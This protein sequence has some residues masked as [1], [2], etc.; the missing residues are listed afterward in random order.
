MIRTIPMLAAI[1]I[2]GVCPVYA[3]YSVVN[4]GAWPNEWPKELEPLRKQSRTFD[5]PNP[6]GT[7]ESTLG[8]KIA[9]QTRAVEGPQQPLLHYAIPFT[10]REDFESA[11]PHILKVKSQGAPII[12]RS[13][14]SFWLVKGAKAGVCVHTPPNG[15]TPVAGDKIKR[16]R[17]EETIYMELIVDG[18]IVD[19]NRLPLP[20]DTPIIDERFNSAITK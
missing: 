5:G 2:L 11:W 9:K 17:W 19:L 18:E 20:A 3:Q 4:R 10:K 14:S 7:L 15:Q 1:S 8:A 12:L 13:G 6:V 16:G